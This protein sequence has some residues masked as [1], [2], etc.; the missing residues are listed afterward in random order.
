M[1]NYRK[2]FLRDYEVSMS[3]GVNESETKMPQRVLINVELYISNPTK[4]IDDK[5]ENVLD[6]DFLRE[7]I[8]ALVSKG[9][10][11]LQETL[12]DKI[13]ELCFL[14]HEVIAVKV[15]S[16]KTEVYASCRSVGFEVFRHRS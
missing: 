9:H 4:C 14:R 15:S 12:V 5:Y 11:N 6:Y 1:Q 10:I 3:I 8:N 2:I 7:G 16:E 13:V